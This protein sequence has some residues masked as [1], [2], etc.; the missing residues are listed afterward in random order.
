MSERVCFVSWSQCCLEY[1]WILVTYEQ[2]TCLVTTRML[3]I[4]QL[5]FQNSLFLLS[6]VINCPLSLIN[7]CHH[8]INDQL[9]I[10]AHCAAYPFVRGRGVRESMYMCAFD[11]TYMH[12]CVQFRS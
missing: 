8:C 11:S 1:D 3:Y 7:K 9:A 4:Q 2:A 6:R 10:F 5:D 12:L